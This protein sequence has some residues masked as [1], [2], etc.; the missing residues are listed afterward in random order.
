[1]SAIGNALVESATAAAVQNSGKVVDYA[2]NRILDAV[3]GSQKEFNKKASEDWHNEMIR[4]VEKN[5]SQ[6]PVS[7]LKDQSNPSVSPAQSALE[8]I[9]RINMLLDNSV[10]SLEE[11]QTITR[12]S[13]CK[14]DI[15]DALDIVGKKTNH[16][17]NAGSRILA[18]QVLKERGDIPHE[19][20]WDDL[21]LKQRKEIDKL[22][23][24]LPEED[25][26]KPK[27]KSVSK[28]RKKAAGRRKN[29]AKAS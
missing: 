26:S 15:N 22:I 5:T 2:I 24:L 20:K 10:R 4:I 21:T 3:F 27:R 29:V 14:R 9:D 19:V 23:D 1:M 6:Q 18:M 11:A 28:P 16:V 13:V 17:R 8:E 25:T 12:C 7:I